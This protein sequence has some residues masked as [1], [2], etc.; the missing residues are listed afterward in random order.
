MNLIHQ[1]VKFLIEAY[2]K[3]VNTIELFLTGLV[4]AAIAG[5]I[6]IA[7]NDLMGFYG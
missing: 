1:A 2:S 6:I 3:N 7:I 4:S 5:S